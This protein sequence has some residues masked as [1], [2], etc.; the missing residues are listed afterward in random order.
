MQIE[1]DLQ[2]ARLLAGLHGMRARKEISEMASSVMDLG[3]QMTM[4]NDRLVAMMEAA[5][6]D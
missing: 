6:V 1:A 3:V 2:L 5:Q 4:H